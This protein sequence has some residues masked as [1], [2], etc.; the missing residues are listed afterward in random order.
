MAVTEADTLF[1]TTPHTGLSDSV[2]ERPVEI[3][4]GAAVPFSKFH[5]LFAPP[6]FQVYPV[7]PV[8]L[9]VVNDTAVELPHCMEDGEGV[10]VKVGVGGTV[11][12][13]A[14]VIFLYELHSFRHL[15]LV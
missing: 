2:L 14:T 15:L 1:G 8:T 10:I 12:V 5:P 3:N 4:C 11:I 9:L 13:S 7:T 6:K